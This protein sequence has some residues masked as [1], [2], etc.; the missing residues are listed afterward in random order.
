MHQ[1]SF[2]AGSLRRCPRP[3]SRLVDSRL[4]PI[5]IPGYAYGGE[6]ADGLRFPVADFH[7]AM[8]MMMMMQ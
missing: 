4:P 7:C 1:N 5:K 3:P 6:S 8:M 2:S